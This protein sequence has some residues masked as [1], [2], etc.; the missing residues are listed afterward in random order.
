MQACVDWVLIISGTQ[1]IKKKGRF[2]LCFQ[3]IVLFLMTMLIP[4]YQNYIFINAHISFCFYPSTFVIHHFH[5]YTKILTLIR[6]G[7]TPQFPI[8]KLLFIP[9]LPT[10]VPPH[11]HLYSPHSHLRSPHSHPYFPH[12]HP[13]SPHSH[14]S[15]P[16]SPHSRPDSPNFHHSP[17]SVPRFPIPTLTDYEFAL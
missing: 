6:L 3:T 1:V 9:R 8:S 12:S 7:P 15:Q 11:F 16:D 4:K 13:D 14:Y 10:L 5:S 2:G 17:S